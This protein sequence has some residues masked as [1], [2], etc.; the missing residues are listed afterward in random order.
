MNKF[1]N[2]TFS[3]LS[4]GNLIVKKLLL[5]E[6]LLEIV[7]CPVSL[8]QNLWEFEGVFEILVARAHFKAFS[9]TAESEVRDSLSKCGSC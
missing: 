9:D 3:D 2:T 6:G 5:T 8:C 1:H 4:C 7:C